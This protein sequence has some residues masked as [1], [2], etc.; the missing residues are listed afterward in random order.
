MRIL[1]AAQDAKGRKLLSQMLELDGHEVLAVAS[2]AKTLA[3][4][5]SFKPD[6]ILL[7][8]ALPDDGY[9]C[10]REIKRHYG[11]TFIPVILCTAITDH[12][13]LSAFLD[14]G[15][16]DFIDAPYNHVVLKAKIAGFE[17]V[18]ELYR[19]LER[20][21]STTE[22]EIKLAKHMF[23]S[24]T[25]RTPADLPYLRHWTLTAGHFCGDLLIFERTPDDQLHIL[26]GDFTGHGLA[27]AVGALPT[28]DV[29]YAMTRKGFSLGEIAAEINR[30]LHQ[31]LPTGQF[32]AAILLALKPLENRIEL[33]NG[34]LPPAL[35]IDRR[36]RIIHRIESA[37][38]PL[39]IVGEE[40]FAAATRT[41]PMDGVEHVILYSDGLVEAQN[42]RGDAFGDHGL[43]DALGAPCFS[44][45]PLELIKSHVIAFLDG[46][47][48]HDDIT[49]LTVSPDAC[50]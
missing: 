5:D 27:A 3:R 41:L 15:A 32:C 29:F 38:L 23:D 28:A 48:P 40:S 37:N 50:R 19:R 6:L 24:V 46:L 20:F 2:G 1:I 21:L 17:R 36:C 14:S 7:D 45:Q 13:S 12:F 11:D 42:A 34:G 4:L 33:W 35:L 39:G 18:G 25:R 8:A 10:A 49:L 43:A 9:H 26:L 22:Q 47:E 30:K 16:D 31:L 44:C